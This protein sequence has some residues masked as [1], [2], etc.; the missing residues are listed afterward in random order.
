VRAII[1]A[2]VSAATLAAVSAQGAPPVPKP[3]DISNQEWAPLSN[4]PPSPALS[5]ASPPVICF[6]LIQRWPYCI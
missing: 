6:T 3:P 2:F 1:L 4:D 5:A